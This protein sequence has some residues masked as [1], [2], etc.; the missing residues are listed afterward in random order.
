MVRVP[1]QIKAPAGA[2]VQQAAH[3]LHAHLR[4]AKV[5]HT[6]LPDALQEGAPVGQQEHGRAHGRA[7]KVRVDR[8]Q[9]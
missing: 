8:R 7:H 1:Y 3:A 5:C 9:R 4:A 2:P 6:S